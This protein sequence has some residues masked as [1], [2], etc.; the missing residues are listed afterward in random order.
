MGVFL[1]FRRLLDAVVRGFLRDDHVV[2]VTLA[3]PRRG[4]LHELSLRMHLGDRRAADVAHRS[5]QPADE[6]VDRLAQRA[7]VRDAAL[8][9]FRHELLR[10]IVRD[11]GLEVAVLRPFLHRADRAHAAVALVAAAL[12]QDDLARRFIGAGEQGA[13]HHGVGTSGERLRDIAGVLD[14]A[15]GDDRG[16]GALRGAAGIGDRGELR[17]A[18]AGDDPGRADRARTDADLAGVAAALD[19]RAGRFSGRLDARDELE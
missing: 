9:A 14:A 18:A 1:A 2:N 15:I 7:L 12:V 8:D 19:Q 16:A 17:D 11:V 3:Q 5:T 6:L 13:D 10:L 4:D